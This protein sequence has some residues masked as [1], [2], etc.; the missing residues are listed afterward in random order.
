MSD[1]T[2]LKIPSKP[3]AKTMNDQTLP[4]TMN[5]QTVPATLETTRD[6][7][8]Q[9]AK[10]TGGDGQGPLT[11]FKEGHFYRGE[12]EIAL[13][14]EFIAHV[15]QIARGHVKF[16]DGEK[17][18]ERIGKPIEGFIAD[19]NF[20]DE[21]D[22]IDTTDDPWQEQVYLPLQD[23]ETGEIVVFV[24]GS[25]GG[26]KAVGQ[27]AHT[28]ANNIHN[29]MPIIRLGTGGY[30]HKKHRK[31]VDTPEFTIIGW[32]GAGNPKPPAKEDLSDEIPF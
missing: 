22:K 17:V 24:S 29:G 2:N 12:I 6:R 10:D 21:K 30:T 1:K 4:K 28:V 15:L 8:R 19:R 7:L 16:V 14:R 13:G 31:W 25:Q 18:D 23:L 9:L 5:D 27:L 20:L 32:T 11:K 26:R 3:E